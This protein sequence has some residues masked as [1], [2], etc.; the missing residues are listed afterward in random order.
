[1]DKTGK[2]RLYLWI[3]LFSFILPL[4]ALNAEQI[5]AQR[6][7]VNV[8]A[9]ETITG[10]DGVCQKVTNNSPNGLAIFVPI[11]TVAE[12]QAFLGH[13]PSGVSVGSCCVASSACAATTCPGE[14]CSDACGNVYNGTVSCTP[15]YVCSGGSCVFSWVYQ[16]NTDCFGP[17]YVEDLGSASLASCQNFCASQWSPAYG[18]KY[19][20]SFAFHYRA[21]DCICYAGEIEFSYNNHRGASTPNM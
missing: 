14:T 3:F 6:W 8:G 9:T 20:A 21:I 5:D 18:N 13:L 1:M 10:P 2:S 17:V 7:K 19:C 16:V 15:P 4:A 12:W 11:K